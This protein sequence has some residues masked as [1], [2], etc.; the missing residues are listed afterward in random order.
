MELG[1]D[2]KNTGNGKCIWV[3]NN[4]LSNVMDGKKAV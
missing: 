2:R 3:L 1:R 4:Q